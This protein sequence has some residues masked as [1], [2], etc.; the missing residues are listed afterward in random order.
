M[1]AACTTCGAAIEWGR[2][3]KSGTAVPLDVGPVSNGNLVVLMRD[4]GDVPLVRI[5]SREELETAVD[6]NREL[7][8]AH[9]ATCP[10]AAK[11]RR[12]S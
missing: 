9:F 2:F 7:R 10:D 8:R 12:R 1:R 4:A 11:H 3:A 5:A 6:R